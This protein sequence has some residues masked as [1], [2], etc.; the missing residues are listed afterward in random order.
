MPFTDQDIVGKAGNTGINLTSSADYKLTDRDVLSNGLTV[1]RRSSLDASASEYEELDASRAVTATYERTR[2]TD[3]NGL[4]LDYNAALKRTFEPRKHELSA[5]V[6]L[7]R[8]KD[9]EHT[10]LW[11]LPAPTTAGTA[12]T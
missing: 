5:E 4:V 3:A 11:R 2:R 12:A 10:A 6:R 1:N 7:N 8:T 9:E